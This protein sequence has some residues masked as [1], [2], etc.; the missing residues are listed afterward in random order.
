LIF[1]EGGTAIKTKVVKF[2]LNLINNINKPKRLLAIFLIMVTVLGFFYIYYSWNSSK[3]ETS[4]KAIKTAS[5]A[6]ESLNGEMLKELNAQPEDLGTTAYESIKSRLMEIVNIDS[7]IRFAYFYTQKAGKIYFMADSEPASSEDYSPPGQDFPEADKEDFQPFIDGKTL[8]TKPVTDRWGTWV[9][10]LVPL[11]DPQTG[12]IIA[13]FGMDYPAEM[14][15]NN[16]IS[17]TIQ[18]AI[19]VFAIF[20]LIMVIYKLLNINNVLNEEKNKLNFANIKIVDAVSEIRNSEEKFSKAFHSGAVLMAISRIEDGCFIDVNDAFL[21]T[22]GFKRDEVI[23]KTSADLEMFVDKEQRAAIKK[24]FDEEGRASNLEVQIKGQ[25]GFIHTGIFSVDSVDV[26]GMPCWLTTL[27]DITERKQAER[28]LVKAKEQAEAATR[29][30]S[31]FLANMSHEIR[32]P[33]NAIMG[34]SEILKDQVKDPKYMGYIDIILSSGK[35]LLGLINDILDLSKIEAGKLEFQYRPVDPYTLFMDISKI[36]EVKIKDKGLRLI[37]DIDGK[38]PTSLLLDEVRIRQILFNLVGNAVKFTPTGYIEL[39]VKG[40]FYNNRSK[41]DLIFS[42]KDTGI[43]IGH[44]DKKIIFDAF[45]QSQGQSTKQYGGTGLGLAITKKLVELMNGDIKVESAV[46]KGSIFT[47]VIK[48]VSISTVG[49]EIEVRKSDIKDISFYNQK[50]L[51]VDDIESNRRVLS[52]L[53]NIYGLNVQEAKNGKE[54]IMIAQNIKPDVIL[55]DLRMPV[56][57]GYEATKILKEDSKLKN[58]PIII[59]TASAMKTSDDDI[60]KIGSDSYLRK[61]ISRPELLAELKKYLKFEIIAKDEKVLG[62]TEGET[63]VKSITDIKRSD[64]INDFRRLPESVIEKLPELVNKLENGISDKFG[65]L[66]KEFIIND[67][68]DFAKDIQKLGKEYGINTLFNWGEKMSTQADSF[69][70]ENLT[71]TLNEFESI[72]NNIRSI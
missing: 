41:I 49:P 56:M 17:R 19:I 70:L 25:N 7:E 34:F 28:E 42:V 29:A 6:G 3:N 39:K 37:T 58:I 43:G 33:M 8:I 36:F 60:K 68:E 44:D 40:V 57:D 50:V 63:S 21:K 35:N 13:V 20:L 10:V 53:L 9:S 5:L 32:T 12:K 47:I 65:K 27:T 14:W 26:A 54:A 38:L 30:K 69:D 22:L 66:K 71:V 51:V 45:Q 2:F 11:K 16:A 72:L 61:P 31:E 67:I 55:M 52:E 4:A 59:L 23:G 15:N 64:S 48:E 18:S 1:L 46:G 62:T 24:I